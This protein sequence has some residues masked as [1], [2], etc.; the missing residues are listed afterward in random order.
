M[1]GRSRSATR[2]EEYRR[3]MARNQLLEG[4][5]RGRKNRGRSLSPWRVPVRTAGKR[6]PGA[7]NRPNRPNRRVPRLLRPGVVAAPRSADLRLRPPSVPRWDRPGP[8]EDPRPGP[9]RTTRGPNPPARPPEARPPRHRRARPGGET[10]GE[11]E[12]LGQARTLLTAF[13]PRRPHPY[14][15]KAL[16]LA[17]PQ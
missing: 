12:E 10:A 13:P 6:G 9:L 15:L 3:L 1:A 5:M 11:A 4:R 8:W 2:L 16:V 7:E 14:V 17:A